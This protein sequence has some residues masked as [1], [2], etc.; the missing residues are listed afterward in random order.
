MK[1]PKSKNIAIKIN[2]DN[3]LIIINKFIKY[4]HFILYSEIYEIK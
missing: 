3:I 2:Y 4:L 1:L